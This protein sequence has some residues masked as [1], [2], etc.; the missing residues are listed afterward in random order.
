MKHTPG[1]WAV[2]PGAPKHV[3]LIVRELPNYK[4]TVVATIP[5]HFDFGDAAVTDWAAQQA[6]AR[7]VAA[8]PALLDALRIGLHHT[9][10]AAAW[11]KDAHRR[12]LEEGMHGNAANHHQA[13]QDTLEAVKVIEAAIA[14][15]EGQA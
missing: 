10:R 12:A 7:L 4:S 11:T 6:N 3:A 15:A 2:R 8:A 9:Q 14:A 1:P 13:W 5:M